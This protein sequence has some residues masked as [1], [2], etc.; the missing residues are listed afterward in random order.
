MKSTKPLGYKSYG[1]IPHLPGSRRG[2]SDK[3]L[4]EKQARLLTE[5]TRDKHD[6]VIVTE[7][8]DGSNVGVAKIDGKIIPIIRSGYTAVDSVHEQHRHFHNWV[9]DRYALFDILLEDGERACGEWLMMAHGTKYDLKCGPFVLF[10]I[11]KGHERK[12]HSE[13][14]LRARMLPIVLPKLLHIGSA[15]SIERAMDILGHEGFHGAEYAEG[16]VWRLERKGRVLFLGK[17]VRPDKE[18]G[19][20]FEKFND[21]KIT[22]NWYPNETN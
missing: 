3:G 5:K 8:I 11:M 1:S 9:M 2:P 19:K 7:K 12:A 22:W 4:E 17:Y 18:D 15:C 20:Y 14:S 21:G 16:A 13:V 10:D 6:I